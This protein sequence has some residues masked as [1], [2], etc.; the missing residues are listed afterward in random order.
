MIS[1]LEPAQLLGLNDVIE[2]SSG[3]WH[4]RTLPGSGEQG[5]VQARIGF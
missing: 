1:E 2:L 3:S 5:D 4:S